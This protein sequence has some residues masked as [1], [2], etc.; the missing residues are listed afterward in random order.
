MLKQVPP[1]LLS[2][3]L[4]DLIY[5]FRMMNAPDSPPS[6]IRR[7][8]FL[9]PDISNGEDLFKLRHL[10]RSQW[11]VL[12]CPVEGLEFP[13]E[14]LTVLNEN[15][16]DR[17]LCED[18]L[19]AISWLE[20]R[21]VSASS[22]EGE[23]AAV[24]A[25]ELKSN[26]PEG[27]EL[28][29][30]IKR[31]LTNLGRNQTETINLE[32]LADETA[33]FSDARTN[34]DGVLP[35]TAAQSEAAHSAIA[36]II[37][38]YGGKEDRT[39]E[40]GIDHEIFSTFTKV[41]PDY[42]NWLLETSGDDKILPFDGET[43]SYFEIFLSA[44]PALDKWFDQWLIQQI[45]P[46]F[47]S[48]EI[49]IQQVDDVDSFKFN[50]PIH[51]EYKTDILH[52]R[53]T[54]LIPHFGIPIDGSLKHS[55]WAKVKECFQAFSEWKER[56]PDARLDSLDSPT[57]QA[58]LNPDVL[59]E[60]DTLFTQDKVIAA[61]LERIQQLQKMILFKRDL[62][63]FA[64]EFSALP[65]IYDPERPAI[66]QS[67]TLYM[68]GRKFHLC[69][70]TDDP[71]QHAKLATESG[72]YLIYCEILGGEKKRNIAAAVTDGTAQ[73]LAIGR[74]G[75]FY[76]R[77][78]QEWKASVVKISPQAISLREGILAPFQRLGE[79][80]ASQFEKISSAREKKI[81]SSLE[82]G[83]DEAA[84]QP[85]TKPSQTVPTMTQTSGL[86]G[87]LAG[88]GLAFAALSSSL[89]FITTSLGKV[90][91]INF[92][93]T[94]AGFLT[95]IILPS[96]IIVG[97]KLRRRDLALLLNASGWAIN[98]RIRLTRALSRRLTEKRKS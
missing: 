69:I 87:I 38:I 22:L 91:K 46:E 65:S 6:I 42:L 52:F 30:T 85:A 19:D 11:V 68:A 82:K 8:P 97:R 48:G 50:K 72:I 9:K 20:K 49:P 45:A 56:N 70:P 34:G 4:W 63:S 55:V 67:G 73:G 13:K 3:V 78:G 60:I 2:P 32:D 79:L 94:G 88:G 51:P 37:K 47:D 31:I 27:K 39:G 93:Y 89:A 14:T 53:D 33:L 54:V 90:D 35:P 66:F 57:I 71:A 25:S 77:K 18:L 75:L 92:L 7:G 58:L 26:T 24:S 43:S 86:G 80:V 28:S 74:H 41:A 12:G 64:R 40:V 61:E 29:E 17:I 98:P 1:L 95:L 23:Q 36:A 81:H 62:L 83:L 15:G 96:L 21:L 5:L 59:E 44:Q 16:D 84:K 76:D 10:D